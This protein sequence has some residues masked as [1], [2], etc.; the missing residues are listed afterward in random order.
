M[1]I[2]ALDFETA[3]PEPGNACQIGLAW[4]DGL[5]ITRVEERYI[6]PRDMNFTFTWCHGITAD[7][8]WDKPEFPEVLEEFR[9][10]LEGAL[11]L[12]HNAG[13]DQ[14]VF[15]GCA[16]SYR[17]KPPSMDFLCTL[18]IARQVWPELKSKALGHLARHLGITFKHHNAAEDAMACAQ[19]AIAAALKLGAYEISD[20]PSR[21]AERRAA[22]RAA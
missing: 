20:I 18:M 12:A 15:H 7:H 6:R 19:V 4:I 10:D 1:K 14:G 9:G 11:V 5:T 16:K 3:C 22:G 2:I 8:V 17:V 21:L 13:F